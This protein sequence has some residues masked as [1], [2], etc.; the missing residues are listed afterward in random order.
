M[1]FPKI[2][3]G[4]Q[5]AYGPVIMGSRGKLVVAMDEGK[6]HIPIVEL[7]GKITKCTYKG[8]PLSVDQA[9]FLLYGP[10]S[11]KCL[12]RVRGTGNDRFTNGHAYVVFKGHMRDKQIFD[13]K[14]KTSSP[15]WDNPDFWTYDTPWYQ[16]S[17]LSAINNVV[18]KLD[19]DTHEFWWNYTDTPD[20][21]EF[22]TGNHSKWKVI[23]D[24]EKVAKHLADTNLLHEKSSTDIIADSYKLSY[25]TTHWMDK[26]GS[27]TAEEHRYDPNANPEIF[28]SNNVPCIKALDMSGHRL[29]NYIHDTDVN[30]LYPYPVQPLKFTKESTT[31][32]KHCDQNAAMAAAPRNKSLTIVTNVTLLN[33]QPIGDYSNEQIMSMILQEQELSA[34]LDQFDVKSNAIGKLKAKHN[35]NVKALYSELDSRDVT[36]E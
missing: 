29:V 23:E 30:L 3:F 10:N 31:M 1:V 18:K 5:S 16:S 26:S 35:D 2:D 8:I 36:A 6:T 13:N 28:S 12:T 19:A 32:C 11:V 25:I 9:L 34:K 33:G 22:A 14:G 4:L 17:E 27:V 7:M 15:V 21:Q 24:D 20:P